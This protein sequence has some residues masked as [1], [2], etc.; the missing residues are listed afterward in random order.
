MKKYNFVISFVSV[1]MIKNIVKLISQKF[2][3]LKPIIVPFSKVLMGLLLL[4]GPLLLLPYIFKWISF[5][6]T[7][8]SYQQI[9][10][11][12]Q[13]LF[14]F[15]CSIFF[16]LYVIKYYRYF[17]EKIN[18]NSKREWLTF[19]E[20]IN[21]K[22]WYY[23]KISVFL[24]IWNLIIVIPILISIPM[25]VFLLIV[26][27]LILFNT[28]FQSI[29]NLITSG[30]NIIHESSLQNVP[31]HE[32]VVVLLDAIKKSIF[33]YLTIG[34]LGIII[35]IFLLPINKELDM[36]DTTGIPVSFLKKAISELNKYNITSTWDDQQQNKTKIISLVDDAM[37][38]LTLEYK[39]YGIPYRLRYF[40]I[41]VGDIK[42]KNVNRD[43]AK[44]LHGFNNRLE[45]TLVRFN[46][47]T[48][49]DKNEI[50]QTLNECISILEMKNICVMEKEDISYETTLK[51]KYLKLVNPFFRLLSLSRT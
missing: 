11:N 7:V 6:P 2:D 10:I 14:V 40:S 9:T 42:N 20:A 1:D 35:F 44:R 31:F 50:L 22:I 47:L 49:N 19:L 12:I 48:E 45:G 37:E 51:G 15:L 43:L 27:I 34:I 38:F 17:T 36:V 16:S 32:I 25:I 5:L 24:K 28:D 8:W 4:V 13:L 18:L 3:Y 23:K 39:L 26:L 29:I 21:L 33:A 46:C 41:L 30:N